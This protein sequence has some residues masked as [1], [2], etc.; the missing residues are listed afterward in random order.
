MIKRWQAQL[1]TLFPFTEKENGVNKE[2]WQE[3]LNVLYKGN[4][5]MCYIYIFFFKLLIAT[6]Y[7]GSNVNEYRILLIVFQY[8]AISC[9]QNLTRK[10]GFPS[11][12]HFI[13][14]YIQY[15]V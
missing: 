11:F 2:G 14:V 8:I 9:Q 7:I 12:S 15:F 6:T 1:N 10:V 4:C 13:S 5:H 3:A